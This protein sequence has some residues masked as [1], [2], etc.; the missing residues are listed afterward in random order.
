MVFYM[1][2][3]L[4]KDVINMLQTYREIFYVCL[5]KEDNDI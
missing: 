3:I 5:L 1:K 4:L 2:I